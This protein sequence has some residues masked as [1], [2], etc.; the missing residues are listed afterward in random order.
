MSVATSQFVLEISPRGD[1]KHELFPEQSAEFNLNLR[2]AGASVASAFA[3]YGSYET[4]RIV[5]Y[6]SQGARI[7]IYTKAQQYERKV[8]DLARREPPEPQQRPMQ[9][10]KG[11]SI[12]FNIWGYRPP[13][14]PGHYSVQVEHQT[15]PSE[16]F[17][18]SDRYSFEIVPAA[19]KSAALS[20]DTANRISSVLAWLDAETHGTAASERLLLRVSA[21]KGH[22]SAMQGATSHGQF[23]TGSLV[24][25]AQLARGSQED[26]L[27]WA[28]VLSGKHVTLIRH[29]LSYPY[30]KSEAE[31]AI[32]DAVPVSRFPS[33]EGQAL[34]LATGHGAKGPTLTGALF[35]QPKGLLQQWTMPLAESPSLTACLARVKR[36]A[37]L[38]LATNRQSDSQVSRIDVTAEGKLS[39]EEK[40]VRRSP[41]IVIAAASAFNAES[42]DAFFVL[43]ADREQADKMAVVTVPMSGPVRA[44]KL[45]P[46]PGWPREENGSAIKPLQTQI[47]QAVDG[48]IAIVF[49]D[50]RGFFYGGK[51]SPKPF[52]GKLRA[53]PESPCTFP[54]VAALSRNVTPACFTSQGLLFTPGAEAEE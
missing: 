33:M 24:S 47:E 43:E 10:G 32:D 26:G 49:V 34:F 40:I 35:E 31:L 23:P 38:L 7:G 8:G 53:N 48:S 11:S 29:N 25:V 2:N 54:H 15:G 46:V 21:V 37:A 1:W 44:P 12:S 39:G 50:S 4:P 51:L 30:W 28:A 5:V 36:P 17:I 16:P 52:V 6:D 20:Y 41:N 3:L 19:V 22:A 13:L 18:S 42:G 9:P 14:P 45:Q 27:G